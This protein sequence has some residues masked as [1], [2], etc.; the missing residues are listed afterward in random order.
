MFTVQVVNRV[1]WDGAVKPPDPNELGWKDT[2]RTNPLEDV[3]IAT[4]PIKLTNVPFKLPNS[5]RPLDVTR[6]IGSLT[7]F[8]NVDP[9]GNPTSSATISPTSG[10]STSGTAICSVTKRT[11]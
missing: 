9:N 10:G 7:G 4:R 1:G 8:T 2:I 3:I 6:P 11:T 5:I